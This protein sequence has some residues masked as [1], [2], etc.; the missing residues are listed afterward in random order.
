MESVST[1]G[2]PIDP[3]LKQMN[4][5]VS[6]S[7]GRN[8]QHNQVSHG[9]GIRDIPEWGGVKSTGKWE[10]YQFPDSQRIGEISP[11]KWNPW[12]PTVPRLIRNS[13]RWTSEFLDQTERPPTQSTSIWARNRRYSWIRRVP[14]STTDFRPIRISE[15]MKFWVTKSSRKTVN[16]IKSR[17]ESQ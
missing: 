9:Y 10:H 4:F 16:T 17:I 11:N 8:R 15:Q 6:R 13:N 12:A 3:K 14:N 1:N 2:P 7:N 5:W